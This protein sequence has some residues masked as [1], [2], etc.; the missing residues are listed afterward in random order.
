[1]ILDAQSIGRLLRGAEDMQSRIHQ[2]I[3][4]TADGKGVHLVKHH[5][6]F[7]VSAFDLLKK[8]QLTKVRPIWSYNLRSPRLGYINVGPDKTFYITRRPYR[9][10]KIGLCNENLAYPP[11]PELRGGGV[12]NWLIA[13]GDIGECVLNR[14]PSFEEVITQFKK[15]SF[16]KSRAFSRS[17]AIRQENDGLL[18][19]CNMDK[20]IGFI[21][22]EHNLTLSPMFNN[23]RMKALLTKAG[24]PL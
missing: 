16:V 17:L 12:F 13:N 18:R 23:S 24:V 7:D 9:H 1:M 4:E 8:K 19:L 10:W 15:R 3:L 6:G 22:Y 2:T 11:I 20:G 14:Y 5:A 21:D